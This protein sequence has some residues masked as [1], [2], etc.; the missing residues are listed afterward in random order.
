MR[1]SKI[2]NCAHIANFVRIVRRSQIAKEIAVVAQSQSFLVFPESVQIPIPYRFRFHTDSDSVL[3]SNLY[4]FEICTES[5]SV[6]I[7]ENK[8]KKCQKLKM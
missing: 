1:Q 3:I 4:G 6:R 7:R 8:I 2:A 5:E